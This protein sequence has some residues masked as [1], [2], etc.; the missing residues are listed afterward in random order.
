M[1]ELYALP[2][3]WQTK[4]MQEAMEWAT[5]EVLRLDEENAALQKKLKNAEAALEGIRSREKA[6]K[7]V[8]A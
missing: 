3:E 2:L 8:R 4:T 1:R 7:E 5:D 6:Q